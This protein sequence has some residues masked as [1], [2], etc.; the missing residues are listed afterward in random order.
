MF[1]APS[2]SRSHYFILSILDISH[3][4][5]SILFRLGRAPSLSP[6]LAKDYIT[7]IKPRDQKQLA[8]ETVYFI[9]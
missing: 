9:L 4:N 5:M 2:F 3:S 1:G 8:E 6:V 7:V